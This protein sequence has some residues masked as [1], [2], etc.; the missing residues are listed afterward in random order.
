[1][2]IKWQDINLGTLEIEI[3]IELK[4]PLFCFKKI[5]LKKNRQKNKSSPI[6][7]LERGF[8]KWYLKF[9]LLSS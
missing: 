3:E 4:S 2:E 1:M 7:Y 5:T 6:L 9:S 8:Q